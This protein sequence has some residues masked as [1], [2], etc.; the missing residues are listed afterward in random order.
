MTTPRPRSTALRSLRP[1]A[2]LAVAGLALAACDTRSPSARAVSN[3][4]TK[5]GIEGLNSPSAEEGHQGLADAVKDMKNLDGTTAE[6][7]SAS[8]LL[9][10]AAMSEGESSAMDATRFERDVRIGLSELAD[11]GNQ[12]SRNSSLAAAAS[13]FDPA[14]QISDLSTQATEKDRQVAQLRKD[15]DETQARVTELRNQAAA[16]L[17][18]AQ[19]LHRQA[20]ELAQRASELSAREGVGLIEQSTNLRR[21]GDA[22][23][24]AS[25][26]TTTQ[27]DQVA[28]RVTE[29]ETLAK[30]YENQK[31]NILKTQE[32][33]RATQAAKRQEAEEA[34]AAASAVAADLQTRTSDLLSLH[35]GN[36]TAAFD[37]AVS[38]Y[39]RAAGESRKA[40]SGAGARLTLGSAQ[41]SVAGLQQRNAQLTNSVASAFETLTQ[42]KPPLPS[43]SDLSSKAASLR[44][45]HAASLEAAKTALEDAKSAFQ[46]VQVKGAAE[47]ERLEQLVGML[48]RLAAGEAVNAAPAPAP[49]ETAT[50]TAAAPGASTDAIPEGAKTLVASAIAA[51]KEGRWDDVKA[52]YVVKTDAGRKM[53]D[54]AFKANAAG[55]RVDKAFRS[56]FNT[57]FAEALKAAPGG[58]MIAS[59]M[60]QMSQGDLSGVDESAVK[61]TKT[62]AGVKIEMGVGM[63]L[64]AAEID[65][66]WKFDGAQ[67][68]AMAPAMAMQSQMLDGFVTMQ[69][70]FAGRVEA[71]EFADANAAAMAFMQAMQSA[72]MGGGGGGGG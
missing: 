8:L 15:R 51:M 9:A 65:G 47:K 25:E 17:R 23:V 19:D 13:A 7:A 58:Q 41:L 44:E 29:L 2:L 24:M 5:V 39:T 40:G 54:A 49:E 1:L 69:E 37:K 31:A 43:S 64:Q 11:L 28:P 18:E 26:Q 50:E 33:L 56:K 45:S 36:Y 55:G 22:K 16:T 35:A 53:L 71:G 67:I 27:A 32:S 14:K 20:A 61:Y 46:G 66:A 10:Q 62:D 52:M 30:Q 34:R 3:A 59:A 21:Q 42:I 63:P 57:S 4:S 72:M 12:W 38:A 48:E 60:A 68:D 6:K 70:S